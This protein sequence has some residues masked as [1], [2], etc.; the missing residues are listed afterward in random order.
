MK[1]VKK[2]ELN[3]EAKRVFIELLAEKVKQHQGKNFQEW[4]YWKRK[5]EEADP[6]NPLL[7]KG[8]HGLPY[9]SSLRD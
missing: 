4:Y 5:L 9:N 8:F 3:K 1:G 6:D 7:E 2:E